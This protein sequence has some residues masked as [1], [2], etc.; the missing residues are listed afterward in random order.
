MTDDVPEA[1]PVWTPVAETT[2]DM[3]GLEPPTTAELDD[4]ELPTTAE[5]E[6]LEPPTTAELPAGATLVGETVGDAAAAEEAEAR[7][8]E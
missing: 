4:L 2:V 1:P 3:E 6:G 7:I 5:L 8:E